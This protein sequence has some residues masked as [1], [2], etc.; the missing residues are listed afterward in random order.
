M[1]LTVCSVVKNDSFWLKIMLKSIK[2]LADEII[3]VDDNSTDNTKD[4]IKELDNPNIQHYVYGFGQHFGN[5]RQYANDK[6]TGDWVLWLDADEVIHENDIEQLRKFIEDAEKEDKFDVCHL[7]Y[8]HF[9]ENF[10]HIDNSECLHQ[11][12]YRLYKHHDGIILN[13]RKNHAL[14]QYEWKGVAL[15]FAARIWHLGYIRGMRKIQERFYRNYH[16]SEIHHPIFQAKW[17]DWHYYGDYPKKKIDP[18]I[19][20]QVIKDAFHMQLGGGIH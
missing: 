15:C 20:P 19:I 7:E 6:A 10:G 8:I 18:R 12:F 4:M 9:I 1:K 5:G 16:M 2:D 11:G 17:R 14:P 3:I 13:K